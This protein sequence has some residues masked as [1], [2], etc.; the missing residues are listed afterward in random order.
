MSEPIPDTLLAFAQSTLQKK[1]PGQD[2]KVDRLEKMFGQ[3]SSR[4]YFRVFLKPS[5]SAVLMKL[6]GGATSPAEEITKGPKTTDL[7]FLN[8]QRV[9]LECG[10]LVPAVLGVSPA[11]DLILL[12]D[13]G[14]KSLEALVQ[15][16]PGE[17]KLFYYRKV[18][19]SLVDLQERTRTLPPDCIAS[20]RRFD[21]DLLNWEFD[22]YWEYGI[23]DRFQ[24]RPPENVAERFRL[25]TR[26]ITEQ[27]TQM[28]QGFVHRDFQSR[29]ILFHQYEFYLIDFQDALLGPLLYDLVALLRDSY[30]AFSPGET[31]R[32]LKY[33]HGIL[34]AHHPYH[35]RWEDLQRDFH[36][37]SVQRKLKDTG[38]FQYIKTVRGNPDFIR[39]VPQSVEYV[40]LA[41]Q[42]LPEY[43]ELAQLLTPFL[44]A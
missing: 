39:H 29:N 43:Q 16:A 9:L 5:G 6:P 17:F 12:E 32:L 33:F 19:D 42:E 40:S 21:A 15:D 2:L 30:I 35:G 44:I 36:L 25:L 31:E 10:V 41:L 23:I 24:K 38:R 34:P 37:L 13:L 28:P 8:I 27:I 20:Q 4:Q 14:D 11:Q 22:H 1:Y 3:A 7:P 26:A 18:L